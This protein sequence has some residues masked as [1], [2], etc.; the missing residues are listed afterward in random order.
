M[1]D[2]VV[3]GVGSPSGDDRAGWLVV[4]RL[5]GRLPDSVRLLSLDRPGSA[6]IPMLANMQRAIV[7]DAMRGGGAPGTI[8]FFTGSGLANYTQGLSSHG[9]GVFDALAL[10]REL[11]SLPENLELYG[12]EIDSRP[13]GDEVSEA[14]LSAVKKLADRI[15]SRLAV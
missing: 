6:L 14:I 13:S 12:M 2:V 15:E 8:R 1:S 11:N 7:V 5:R 4:E 9:I 10:A 3:I